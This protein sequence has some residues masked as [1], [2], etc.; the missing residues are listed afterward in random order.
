M[1]LALT[2]K[3]T[4]IWSKACRSHRPYS[5]VMAKLEIFFCYILVVF[6][7]AD[8]SET[9]RKSNKG[10]VVRKQKSHGPC[11]CFN[12]SASLPTHGLVPRDYYVTAP[13]GGS[14]ST[15]DQF[16]LRLESLTSLESALPNTTIVSSAWQPFYVYIPVDNFS[17]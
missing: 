2:S 12:A 8:S 7:H 3:Y 14:S 15:R 1:N 4:Y 5:S 9:S 11:A 6:G 13:S 10:R 17:S 16:D